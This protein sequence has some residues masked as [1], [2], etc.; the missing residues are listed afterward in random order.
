MNILH[1]FSRSDSKQKEA[2][3]R[4]KE[5]R[6]QQRVEA[7]KKKRHEKISKASNKSHGN[8]LMAK[9]RAKK[10]AKAQA[11]LLAK[12]K[13]EHIEGKPPERVAE[14][15][16]KAPDV[17]TALILPVLFLISVI[18]LTFSFAN[19]G[20]QHHVYKVAQSRKSMP[21][22][23]ELPVFKGDQKG[24]LKVDNTIVSKD[25][26]HM[27]VS[28]NYD[29]TAHQQLSSF[30]KEYKIW[31]IGAN[32]YPIKDLSVKYG[33]FGTDGNAVLQINS[34]K[35]MKN[36]AF[37]VM[38]IDAGNLATLSDVSQDTSV[39]DDSSID[40]TITSQLSSGTTNSDSSST[41]TN[42]N[43]KQTPPM[44]YIRLNPYSA[45]KTVPYWGDD[46]KELVDILFVHKNLTKIHKEMDETKAKIKQAKHTKS[47][48]E[49]RL[50]ENPQDQTATEGKQ[51]MD[52]SLQ[53]LEQTLH[54]EQ[55]NYTKLE[56]AKFKNNVLGKQQTKSHPFYTSKMQRFTNS[57]LSN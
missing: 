37:V 41:D 43:D 14:K 25:R 53:S 42:D 18:L 4:I 20:W 38:I 3:K 24:V 17:R 21:I 33:F 35:P 11:K 36:E 16:V 32:G 46:E 44:Y 12:E 23:T 8:G 13:K 54:S 27:A 6:K 1:L 56:N 15:E 30:G 9:H 48:Y 28:I 50:K 22:N 2:K 26:K 19:I 57:G 10:A 40:Q 49:D 31:L 45:H 34:D 29:K 47:E 52:S 7:K 5:L 55:E 51:D 39:T